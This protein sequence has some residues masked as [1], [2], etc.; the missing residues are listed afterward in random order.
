MRVSLR[1]ERSSFHQLMNPGLS[2][3]SRC[4][5]ESEGELKISRDPCGVDP[6]ILLQE[7]GLLVALERAE[8]NVVR[9]EAGATSRHHGVHLACEEIEDSVGGSGLLRRWRNSEVVESHRFLG[10]GTVVVV[11][12]V[13]DG[14][15]TVGTLGETAY[16]EASPVVGLGDT[17]EGRVARAVSERFEYTP[18]SIPC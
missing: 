15:K 17:L 4:G 2:I 18:T 12:D 1:W 3:M 9:E 10:V 13:V 7:L 14:E 6:F 11:V 5:R 8:Q 16:G